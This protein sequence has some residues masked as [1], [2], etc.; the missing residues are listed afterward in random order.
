M[1]WSQPATCGPN[2]RPACAKWLFG[3]YLASVHQECAGH[4]PAAGCASRD[5]LRVGLRLA[6]AKPLAQSVNTRPQ[7]QTQNDDL[8]K[9]D[10]NINEID[11]S[12]KMLYQSKHVN[13]ENQLQ[14]KR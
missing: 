10:K 6:V 1:G 8:P 3:V 13:H 11:K 12:I 7:L 5:T 9:S 14:Q 2:Q 4:Q